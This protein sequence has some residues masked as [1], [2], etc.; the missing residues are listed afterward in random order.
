MMYDIW[1]MMI[2]V[3]W[4]WYILLNMFNLYADVDARSM[5][6]STN[7]R[8][9]TLRSVP[10]VSQNGLESAKFLIPV[11]HYNFCIVQYTT[12]I[13]VLPQSELNTPV[14][15]YGRVWAFLNLSGKEAVVQLLHSLTLSQYLSPSYIDIVLAWPCPLCTALLT[16]AV[17]STIREDIDRRRKMT[18]RGTMV[19]SEVCNSCNLLGVINLASA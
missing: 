12:S 17:D 16:M 18:V 14:C 11:P 2:Q 9:Y 1:Y 8:S 13:R 6:P 10:S 3:T 7:T 5:T 4:W 19:R 15:V